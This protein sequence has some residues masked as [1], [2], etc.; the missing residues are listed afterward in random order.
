M[1]PLVISRD[2]ITIGGKIIETAKSVITGITQSI[3]PEPTIKSRGRMYPPIQNITS[4]NHLIEYQVYGNGNY[5][6]NFSSFTN[7]YEPWNVFNVNS[8]N[9]GNW[10]QNRYIV[11][12]GTFISSLTD[13]IVPGYTG[14]WLKIRLPV[15]IN[16]TRYVIKL[17]TIFNNNDSAPENF[18][19]YGSKNGINW[20]E[21]T[22]ITNTVY[23]NGV[24]D[25]SI[26]T[27][28]T[29]N[30]FGLVVNK[31]VGGNSFN[32][33]LLNIRQWLIYGNELLV[34]NSSLIAHYRFDNVTNIGLNSSPVGDIFNAISN[35]PLTLTT[36]KY[37][38]GN[39]S[40]LTTG[41]Q[42]DISFLIDNNGN[43]L[44][45]YVNY[46]SI[47]ISFWCWTISLGSDIGIIF[48]GSP[49]NNGDNE[50]IFMLY[51]QDNVNQ[52]RLI[53]SRG[54]T[55]EPLNISVN[56][57]IV[58][59]GWT[60]VTIVIEL[61]TANINLAQH[62]IKSYV[63]GLLHQIHNNKFYPLITNNYHFQIGRWRDVSNRRGYTG[64]IDDFRIYNNA[65]TDEEVMLL[66]LNKET[67]VKPIVI[68]NDYNYMSFRHNPYT[69]NNLE[70]MYPPIRNVSSVNHSITG[71]DYGNGNY[72]ISFSSSY[73]AQYT[74]L[75]V[76]MLNQTP[77]G[78]W[79]TNNRYVQ[80][81]G[82]FNSSLTDNIVQGYNGDWIKIKFPVAIN[83]TKYAFK[84]TQGWITNAPENFKIYGSNDEITWIELI[85]VSNAVYIEGGTR[86]Y[87][88]TVST[89]G[90]Y[91]SFG[92]VVNKLVGNDTY[93]EYMLYIEQWFIYGMEVSEQTQYSITFPEETIC[94]ILIVAGGGGGGTSYSSTSS[95]SGGGGGAG[96]L[97]FLENQIVQANTYTI[98]VG[99]GGD[100][101][102]FNDTTSP[103]R[104]KQGENSSFSYHPIEGVGG[105]GGGS[106]GEIES[107]GDGGSG[108]GS[109]WGNGTLL[110]GIGVIGQGFNGG[111]TEA[112]GS[113]TKQTPFSTGGGGAGGAG[114][115][116]G[117]NDDDI[118]SDGGIGKYEV[119]TF[120]FKE[121]FNF[122]TDN[123]IGEVFEG[124]VYFAGGGGAGLATDNN[125]GTGGNYNYSIGG[126]GGG[127]GN[128]SLNAISNT[129]GGGGGG[130]PAQLGLT[131][132]GNGGSGIV[133]IRYKKIIIEED[134]IFPLQWTYNDTNSSVYHLGNV[135]IGTINPTSALDVLGSVV[136]NGGITSTSL[137]ANAKNFKIAHP[138][139]IN[140]WLYHGCVE[141]PRF[142]NMYRGKK[143]VIDGRCEVD[144]DNECNTTGG[145]TSGTFM[146][147]N[148][149]CQ[150]FLE[151]KQTYDMVKGEVID[152]KIIISCENITEEIE[153]E[154]L[155]I[156]ERHDE[157]IIRN[158]LTNNE[159]MLICE[160]E[161]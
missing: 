51:H 141:G 26:T 153:V 96:G 3:G 106:R 78:N 63:N 109:A 14:D 98:Q 23:V 88:N 31:I 97:I 135:G 157:G 84:I 12:D 20:V 43:K 91:N 108:G 74:P 6:I 155:V 93:H 99:K 73:S 95:V 103:L 125:T 115:T 117:G 134:Y 7:D 24:Y 67:Y 77:G 34:Q 56:M 16:L 48:Y 126:K 66:F 142:D 76:F 36:E 81:T 146:A 86:T 154:W 33:S 11:P 39:S 113:R 149:N 144:I 44:F 60:H 121:K 8:I 57:P 1:P 110:G 111:N 119:G 100:G 160:H 41:S 46:K 156:G 68:N 65:L 147:L 19:I 104:G 13:N 5:V 89:S 152:G 107:G 118:D 72:V 158:K 136:V 120:N 42:N 90:T 10:G 137:V 122:P 130:T 151:N 105:G 38:N 150:V 128:L 143:M 124:N 94:D 28:G 80:S 18:K 27:I 70:R 9:G 161:Y 148:N 30:N 40:L 116:N 61:K 2:N 127:G 159:G 114:I 129:G 49:A 75:Y 32:A 45:T 83:L 29:Y 79:S 87:E 59:T 140:K 47:S 54:T 35:G 132:G 50:D 22:H 52:L 4:V 71:Q 53:I 139:N 58:N 85:H 62:T 82:Q 64:Y 102:T 15:A 101:D 25:V 138:L 123:T 17:S 112:D 21:L 69:L 133:I 37:V 131:N 55:H 145:M 92:L